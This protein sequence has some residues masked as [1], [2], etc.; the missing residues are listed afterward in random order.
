MF[1]RAFCTGAST[2]RSVRTFPCVDTWGVS[3]QHFGIMQR[4]GWTNKDFHA[5]LAHPQSIAGRIYTKLSQSWVDQLS[6]GIDWALAALPS[7][8]PLRVAVEAD[9]RDMD[10][11]SVSGPRP[12]SEGFVQLPAANFTGE[13]RIVGGGKV[14]LDDR[15]CIVSLI[16]AAGTQWAGGPDA[17]LALLRY[18]S[19]TDAQFEHQMRDSY[20]M[21]HN[22]SGD[23]VSG[24]NEY[25]KPS[26]D[27]QHPVAQLVAPTLRSV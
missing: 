2:L 6:W 21:Q 17:P 5:A 27:G 24:S 25:G 12:V 20:L 26:Q 7:A 4:T 16:D 3:V 13:I 15:G 23:A 10:V 11:A 9:F 19:V 8:H 18:Q 1:D 14:M 22:Q